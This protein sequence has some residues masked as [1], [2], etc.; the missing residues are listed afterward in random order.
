M[1]LEVH[2]SEV[3]GPVMGELEDTGFLKNLGGEIF[4]S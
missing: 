1:G 3:K 2:L 4:L